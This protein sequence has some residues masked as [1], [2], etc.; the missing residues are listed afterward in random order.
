MGQITV[1]FV[2]SK[3]G[4]KNDDSKEQ[5]DTLTTV[6]TRNGMVHTEEKNWSLLVAIVT[7]RIMLTKIE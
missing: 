5:I 1:I 2:L 4:M 3:N 7:K 6:T